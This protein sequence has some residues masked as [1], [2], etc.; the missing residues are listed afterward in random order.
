MKKKTLLWIG[1]LLSQL[2]YSQESNPIGMRFI[3]SGSYESLRLFDGD[4]TMVS[5]SVNAFWMSN[6]ITNSEFREFYKA[7]KSSPEDTIFW[8]DFKN[9]AYDRSKDIRE[10]RQKYLKFAIHSE[11]LRSLIDTEIVKS[12]E[13]LEKYE[14]YFF[15]SKFNNY[16]VLGVSY[17]GARLYCIWKTECLNV[18]E[19]DLDLLTMSLS[20]F[21]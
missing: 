6:E 11:I 2:I 21:D 4:S 18:V 16:P 13:R 1:I 15:N 5:I 20:L 9:Y 12:D 3:P 7:V 10:Y 19:K 8:F 17:E 14:N